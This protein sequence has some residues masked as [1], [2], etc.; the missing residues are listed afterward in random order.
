MR[1][2]NRNRKGKKRPTILITQIDMLPTQE[3]GMWVVREEVYDQQTDR[4]ELTAEHRF[5]TEAEAEKFIKAWVSM[6]TR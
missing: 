4:A 1:H 3:D 5:T 2:N 6:S